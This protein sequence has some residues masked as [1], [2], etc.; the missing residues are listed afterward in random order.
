MWNLIFKKM[1]Q[2]NLFTKNRLTDIKKK[3]MVTK[4]EMWQGGMNQKLGI[5][6]YTLLNIR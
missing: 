1:I 3:L 2:M 6:I 5:N 4:G